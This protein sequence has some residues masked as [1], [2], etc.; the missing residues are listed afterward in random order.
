MTLALYRA[1]TWAGLPLIRL[2]LAYRRERGKEDAAR[3][4]E[5]LGIPGRARPAGPLVWM[6]AASVGESLAL[7]PLIARV[8]ALR[9]DAHVLITTGTVTSARLLADRL[10]AGA[11]HQYVPVDR[12]AY[13]RRFLDHWR[14]DLVLWSESEF[15]PN[16]VTEP[17]ARGIPMV[18]VQGRVSDRS[19]AGWRRSPNLIRRLLAGFALCLAQ[20][21]D[22]AHRLEALGA[23]RVVCRGNLKFAAP[24]LPVDEGEL[25]RLTAALKDRPRWLAASTH[26]GEESIAARVHQ[27]LKGNHSGLLTLIVP[28]HPERGSAVACELRALGLE[29]ALR[30]AR[31]VV[32]PSI[33]VYLADTLGELGLFYRLAPIAFVGK[34]L[35]PLGGQNPLEPARLGCAVVHGPHMT[36]FADIVRRMMAVGASLEVADE[37]ALAA[38]IGRLLTDESA[39]ARLVAAAQAFAATEGGA[40]D[41]ALAELKPYLDGLPHART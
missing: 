1:A 13:V 21:E 7:L 4:G 39:R 26:P 17:A 10:P 2:Y 15:W 3:F 6:H 40:L 37:A 20:S 8:R 29:V 28:R 11:F 19:L 32:T 27:R 24:P 34:S 12:G 31:Q 16:L 30:S 22:D 36:N 5:R 38:A 14:P 41:A 9:P 18:L 23:R 25:A 35:V 33:D